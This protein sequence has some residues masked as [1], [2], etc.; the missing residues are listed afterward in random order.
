MPRKKASRST[1]TVSRPRAPSP[2]RGGPVVV[3]RT[4]AQKTAKRIGRARASGRGA[5]S[6]KSKLLGN[7]IGGFGVGFLE[8]SFGAKIPSI[9]VVGRKGAIA[10]GMYLFAPK[11]EIAQNI[12][13]AAAALSGYEMAKEGKIS[14]YDDDYDDDDDDD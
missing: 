4:A 12:G 9:P 8:K 14:G 5:S 10:I 3:V 2:A 13:T 1:V 6:F 7:A 11:N